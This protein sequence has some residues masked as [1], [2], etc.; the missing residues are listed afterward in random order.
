MAQWTWSSCAGRERSKGKARG[1]HC[2]AIRRNYLDDQHRAECRERCA[3]KSRDGLSSQ[4]ADAGDDSRETNRGAVSGRTGRLAGSL[5]GRRAAGLRAPDIARALLGGST[6]T[7]AESAGRGQRASLAGRAPTGVHACAAAR[8][9]LRRSHAW[10]LGDRRPAAR[11]AVTAATGHW[12]RGDE[13]PCYHTS[14]SRALAAE[15]VSRRIT[16]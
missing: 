13:L 2:S 7:A 10:R 16:R 4:Q 11:G 15:C 1:G 3:L 9:M 8:S 14:N 6:I 12:R 5:S